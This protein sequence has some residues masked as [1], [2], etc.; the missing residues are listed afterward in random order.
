MTNAQTTNDAEIRPFTV[1]IPEEALVDL[2]QRLVATRWP[3]KEIVADS[4]QGVQLATMKE[5]VGYWLLD[6][7][8]QVAQGGGPP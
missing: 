8:P 2:R 7:R 1:N 6:N 3:D 5:L 4:S